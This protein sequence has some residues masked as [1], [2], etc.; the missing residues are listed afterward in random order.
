MAFLQHF[1]T[2][3]G[4]RQRTGVS[5]HPGADDDRIESFL[6]HGRLL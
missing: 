6:D 1:Q 3:L 4:Q 2:A 5:G